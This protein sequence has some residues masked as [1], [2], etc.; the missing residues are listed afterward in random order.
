MNHTSPRER[1]Q[2]TRLAVYTDYTYHEVGGRVFAERAFALFLARLGAQFAKFTVIGRIAPPSE[3]GRYELGEDVELVPLPYYARLSEPLAV[4]KGMVAALRIYWRA[5]RDTDCV[6]LF[7]PHPLAFPF[8]ALAWVRRKRV[9]LTVRQDLPEYVRNRH[10]NRKL[11]RLAGWILE[12]AFR[13]LGRFCRVVAVGPVIAD[14]YRHSRRLLE[15]SVSLVE[16]AD[17][18]AP[19][20][21]QMDYGG[22]LNV[23]SVGRLDTEKNPLLL[24]DALARLVDQDRRWRL[25]VCG[26]GPLADALAAR[27]HELGVDGHAELKGYVPLRGGLTSLYRECQMLLHVSWTEGLPQVLYEAFAAALPVVATDVGGVAKATGEAVSLIPPGSPEAAAEALRELGEN[28]ALRRHRIEAGHT[29]VSRA[30][31]EAE[32]ARVTEFISA[33]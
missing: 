20:S 31:I 17:V 6:W 30:T 5:L 1:A 11:L 18:V 27:L 28:E 29:L 2:S 15:I 8:A 10:P 19:R 14:H 13:G 32:C 12:L 23:L 3:R 4:L 22:E 33:R 7:G 9:V 21:K 24:A 16:Q 26:E 25:I